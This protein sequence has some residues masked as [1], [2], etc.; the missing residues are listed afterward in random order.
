MLK[1]IVEKRLKK[2]YNIAKIINTEGYYEKNYF[3]CNV[4]EFSSYSRSLWTK[5][6]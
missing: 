3:T 1:N 4:L 5:S 6:N 2:C